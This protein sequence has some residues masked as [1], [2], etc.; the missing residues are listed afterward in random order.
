MNKPIRVLIIDDSK[1]IRKLLRE[2]LESDPCIKVV[3]TAQDPYIAR[4]KIKKLNPDVLT[5]DVE[6]PKNGWH[7]FFAQSDAFT[8]NA[9]CYGFK[10]RTVRRR[11]H[12]KSI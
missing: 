8:P 6:M 10:I 12:V 3:G 7:Y 9:C 11:C 5:L 1:Q 2:I 4:E